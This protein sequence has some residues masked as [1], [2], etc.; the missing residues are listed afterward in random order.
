[1]QYLD[2]DLARWQGGPDFLTGSRL[3]LLFE[4]WSYAWTPL[5]EARLIELSGDGAHPA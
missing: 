5:V 2:T 1:M 3:E 4:E